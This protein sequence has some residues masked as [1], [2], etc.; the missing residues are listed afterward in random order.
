VAA[1]LCSFLHAH[2]LQVS[3]SQL[4]TVEKHQMNLGRD[5]DKISVMD[6]NLFVAAT[7]STDEGMLFVDILTLT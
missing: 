2:R 7:V 1:F 4:R 6:L 5:D 3:S